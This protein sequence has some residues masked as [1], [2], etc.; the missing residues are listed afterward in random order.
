MKNI[1]DKIANSNW[2]SQTTLLSLAFWLLC[3]C[4]QSGIPALCSSLWASTVFLTSITVWASLTRTISLRWLL[5]CFAFGAFS[6]ALALIAIQ[7][8][9]FI[10]IGF[11]SP[12]RP[13]M[14][15]VIDEFFL[16]IPV[17]FLMKKVRSGIFLAGVT[18]FLLIAAWSGAGF[19]FLERALL[20]QRVHAV[21][22]LPFLP[23]AGI[24]HTGR[25]GSWLLN[26][27]AILSCLAGVSIGLAVLCSSKRKKAL[28]VA[29][30]GIAL[31]F[32]DHLLIGN[33]GH[34]YG[35]GRLGT[36]LASLV[37][38]GWLTL[39][40]FLLAVAVAIVIDLVLLKRYFPPRVAV[41]TEQGQAYSAAWLAAQID[42]RRIAFA[43][44]H[45]HNHSDKIIKHEI[46]A[47]SF[48][49]LDSL[50]KR[51]QMLHPEFKIE[52]AVDGENEAS[53]SARK[54]SAEEQESLFALASQHA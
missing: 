21:E 12:L 10:G 41:L 38:Y 46:S 24:Q 5:D 50:L 7:F 37:G 8:F 32:L 36:I 29:T 52:D 3:V 17:L 44:Y 1:L 18:D 26:T 22:W 34:D 33:M 14:V 9:N 35:E 6:G 48:A 30:I 2:R 4:F 27:H 42:K 23:L 19:G 47:L 25:D 11:N 16:L 43:S 20:A 15:A 51:Y 53:E 13:F 28:L 54:I 45:F 49:V 39:F 31:G 40:I